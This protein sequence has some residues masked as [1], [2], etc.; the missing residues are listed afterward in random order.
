MMTFVVSLVRLLLPLYS[1][2][3]SCI[4]EAIEAMYIVLQEG[5]TEFTEADRLRAVR[6]RDF[7]VIQ[8]LLAGADNLVAHVTLAWTSQRR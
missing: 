6:R 5:R 1:Q 3:C 2:S 8:G 4:D 7:W